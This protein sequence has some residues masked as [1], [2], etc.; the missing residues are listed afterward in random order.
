VKAQEQTATPAC[1]NSAKRE[2]L[3]IHESG[4][5]WRKLSRL[6]LAV[7]GVTIAAAV[8]V[9]VPRLPQGICKGDSGGLQLACATLG[10]THPPG[11]AGYASLG[12]LATLVPGTDPAY[13]VT[14][15]GLAYGLLTLLL[16]ILMQ[17]RLGVSVG[18][19]CTMSLALTVYPRVWSNLLAP[20]VYM[21]SL[22]FIAAAAYLL[23]RY[24]RCG[25]R[26]D[27][28]L[29]A[30]PLGMALGNRP[31]V[32][33]TLPFFLLAWW[34]ASKRWDGS[35]R[36]S[37]R[38]LALTAAVGA[39]PILYTLGYVWVRDTPRTPYNYIEQF[40]AEANALPSA[41]EGPKAKARRI[42][43]LMTGQQ[44][45]DKM[46]NTW[47]G[48]RQ[49]LRWLRNELIPGRLV[50]I[51]LMPFRFIVLGFGLVIIVLAAVIAFQRCRVETVL[52]AGMAMGS[53]VFV[54]M[55]R[56]H[57][58]AADILPVLFVLAVLSGVALSPMFPV[59][60][61]GWRRLTAGGLAAVACI[62]TVLDAP[63]RHKTGHRLNGLPFLDQV[64]M[65]TLPD[66]AVI[67]SHW[68]T[69]TPLW[70]AQIVLFERTDIHIINALESEWMRMAEEM[71]HRPIFSATKPS[72]HSGFTGT[73][74]RNLWRLKRMTARPLDPE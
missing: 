55:Y 44:F 71:F 43:W 48:I 37:V 61:R 28:Y 29:A 26:R 4:R 27:L 17:V 25:L 16:C 3:G 69:S 30:L 60:I 6:D 40:N 13:M 51:Q 7:I 11:Y 5:G 50:S 35:W 21:P 52:L 59:D 10:I 53:V 18:I 38:S 1:D 22:M 73:P 42:V 64:D 46:G 36:R 24:W 19:A 45:S 14:L 47:A 15:A 49:K 63:Y 20:E 68:G 74:F 72:F 65:P 32:A 41:D 12:Y 57:G 2:A 34:W 66:G 58:D 33:L 62:V 9:T 23:T 39:V 70:Y 56:M 8:L 67:C 54:C 31:P